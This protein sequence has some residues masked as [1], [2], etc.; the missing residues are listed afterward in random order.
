MTCID[1]STCPHSSLYSLISAPLH[2]G[3][4]R[5]QAT[6]YMFIIQVW[7]L[8]TL[9]KDIKTSTGVEKLSLR[10]LSSQIRHSGTLLLL[11]QCTKSTTITY[12]STQRCPKYCTHT[13]VT[14]SI[15]VPPVCQHDS[16]SHTTISVLL[17]T[18]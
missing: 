10:E 11:V 7:S 1:P 5:F 9:N 15:S 6:N 12:T 2:A 17:N 13:L 18:H 14:S 4:C 8:T 16:K 3:L